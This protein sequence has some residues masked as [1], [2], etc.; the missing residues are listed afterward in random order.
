MSSRR[1]MS[2]G[3]SARVFRTGRSVHGRNFATSMRGGYRI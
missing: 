2:K 3:S 1:G